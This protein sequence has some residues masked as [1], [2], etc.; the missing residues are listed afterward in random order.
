MV[1]SKRDRVRADRLLSIVL[2]IQREGQMTA[3][4]LARILGVTP[5]TIYR[6][7]DALSIAGV[8]IYTQPGP[9]GGC[10][11]DEIYRN[12]LTWFTTNELQTLMYTGT[13]SPLAE[14]GMQNAMENAVLKLFALLPKSTSKQ[15]AIMSQR[16]YLDP[17]AWYSQNEPQPSLPNL[18]E[19]VWDDR[20]IQ[21]VYRNWQGQETKE[22]LAPYGLVYKADSWYLVATAPAKINF[23]TYRVARLS[24][25]EILEKHFE[26][27]TS[28]QIAAYWEHASEKFRRGVPQYPVK[29]RTSPQNLT[30]FY[31]MYAGRFEI[32][33]K[34]ESS[35]V[36]QV[37]FNVFAE[38]RVSCLG[39]GRHTKVIEP[40]ELQTAINEEVK[41]MADKLSN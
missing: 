15:A 34:N 21:C 30:Y 14:L 41:W 8:P 17:T 28:F 19:A 1:Q 9:H 3:E 39:L 24:G 33:E 25:V 23:R 32:L 26:R 18:K 16:L 29:L 13:A 27:E 11:L 40:I 2:L 31:E 35:L 38:A 20:L 7:I 36:L 12:Q 37:D 5:R 22:T 4:A 6:D 10:F